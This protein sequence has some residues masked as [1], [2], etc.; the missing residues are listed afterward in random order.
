MVEGRKKSGVLSDVFG[1][2]RK[3]LARK[4]SVSHG[5]AH[6]QANVWDSGPDT[7]KSPARKISMFHDTAHSQANVWDSGPD[8]NEIM[9]AAHTS[10]MRDVDQDAM[11]VQE[12][13]DLY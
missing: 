2:P 7:N 3:S 11:S 13:E 1:K 8:M 10:P 12:V 5:T 6:S 9:P 4:I